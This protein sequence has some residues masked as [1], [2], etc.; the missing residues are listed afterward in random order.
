MRWRA[1]PTF[2]GYQN[3]VF[4]RRRGA[5]ADPAVGLVHVESHF[6]P[7]ISVTAAV[8]APALGAGVALGR[9]RLFPKTGGTAARVL[10][11][12][13]MSCL[14]SYSVL[15]GR[16]DVSLVWLKSRQRPYLQRWV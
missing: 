12:S 6:L 1:N 5:G 15:P 16:V 9:S 11:V 2:P 8:T 4:Y 10:S 13:S 3:L 7:A 14:R